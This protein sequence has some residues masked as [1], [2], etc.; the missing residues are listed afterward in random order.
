MSIKVKDLTK[1]FVV[2]NQRNFFKTEK[3]SFIAVDNISFEVNDGEMV[4]FIGRNGAGKSTT[5]KMLTGII[6]S[7]KGSIDIDSLN[8]KYDR[9][10]LS[11]KIGCM[12]GQRSQLYMHL[13]VKESFILLGS[14]YD[15]KK[16][17]TLKQIEYI[18]NLF[19]IG[20]LIDKTVKQ[21]SLGQRMICEIAASIIHRPKILFLDEPTIGLD[22]IAKERVRNVIKKLNEKEKITVFL[23]SHD[24]KDIENLCNRIII[25]NNGR[26]I[27]DMKLIE[28]KREYLSKKEITIS[29]AENVV[30][31][32]F[33][34]NVEF[35]DDKT[36]KLRIDTNISKISE[37]IAYFDRLGFILDMQ[38]ESISMEEVIKQIYMEA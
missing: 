2:V 24:M 5:I 11:Y 25:I 34:Y 12:F 31:A 17:E 23:T 10:K 28:L 27:K 37:V 22:M 9:K 19:E 26:I 33:E 3:S 4:A 36:V 8:P 35:L 1:E 20:D 16:S 7:S 38:I 13:S 21:L 14:I 30:N 15:M 29:F 32:N 6:A 18:T